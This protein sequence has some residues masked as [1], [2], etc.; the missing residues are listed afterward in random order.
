MNSTLDQMKT[1]Q[2]CIKLDVCVQ[3]SSICQK[4]DRNCI[5]ISIIQYLINQWLSEKSTTP[6]PIV[7]QLMCKH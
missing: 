1:T 7:A 4:Y 3:S 2:L 6:K 5:D